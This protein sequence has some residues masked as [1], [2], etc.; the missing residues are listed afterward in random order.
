MIRRAEGAYYDKILQLSGGTGIDSIL[1]H[2]FI[3]GDL[4]IT[5]ANFKT[6]WGGPT[7]IRPTPGSALA[8][9]LFS[10]SDDDTAGGSG[11]EACLV[12]ALDIDYV[13]IPDQIV[14]MNGTS[15]VA[16]PT[17]CF[18][19]RRLR[20]ID[21][22]GTNP[23]A[24]GDITIQNAGTV[25]DF[26]PAG[27]GTSTSLWWTAATD[28]VVLPQAVVLFPGADSLEISFDF[29]PPGVAWQRVGVH[30]DQAIHTLETD[31]ALSQHTE[32]TVRAKNALGG[33]P[34]NMVV[35]A[36]LQTVFVAG[37]QPPKD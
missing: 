33:G 28:T 26:M 8:M 12:E 23:E 30:V 36:G 32:M 35:T 37:G 2:N 1:T 21:P 18:R 13:R 16:V 6:V 20:G 25:Y 27:A 10:T 9:T 15:G 5:G 11:L 7:D 19:V 29:K 22:N 34:V 3:H 31:T 17:N 4:P 24:V 14:P